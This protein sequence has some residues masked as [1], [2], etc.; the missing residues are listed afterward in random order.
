MFKISLAADPCRPE[1]MKFR[2]GMFP[3]YSIN[4]QKF[5]KITSKKL[6]LFIGLYPSQKKSP[7]IL[8][9]IQQ[10]RATLFLNYISVGGSWY[11]K[12][13][14]LPYS[15]QMNILHLFVLF[16]IIVGKKCWNQWWFFD[17]WYLIVCEN[18]WEM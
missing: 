5:G 12:R 17:T 14:N 18:L 13:F 4:Y 2:S 10:R 1:T 9:V 15:R 3:S 16:S 7:Y 11:S 6:Q 8:H